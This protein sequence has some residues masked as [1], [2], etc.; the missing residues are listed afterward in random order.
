MSELTWL[1][2][3]EWAQLPSGI[4]THLE[5]TNE[6]TIWELSFTRYDGRYDF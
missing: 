2:L 4:W 6:R 1:V 5:A 3:P